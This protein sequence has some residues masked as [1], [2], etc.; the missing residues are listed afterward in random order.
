MFRFPAETTGP[1]AAP[2]QQLEG[3]QA[4][5]RASR[6]NERFSVGGQTRCESSRALNICSPKL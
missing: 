4:V 1:N 2:T 6:D 3:R 5:K